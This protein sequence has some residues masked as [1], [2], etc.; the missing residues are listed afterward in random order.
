MVIKLDME[1]AY[2]RLEQDFIKA[3][4]N[5]IRFH[6]KWIGGVMECISTVSYSIFINDRQGD[7]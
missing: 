1:K 6:S 4:L 2:D 7:W 3:F 5:I